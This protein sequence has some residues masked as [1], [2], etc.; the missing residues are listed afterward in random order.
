[1]TNARIHLQ[2]V[3]HREKEQRGLWPQL[4]LAILVTLVAQKV[5][6]QELKTEILKTHEFQNSKGG[7]VFVTIQRVENVMGVPYQ[8][9]IRGSCGEAKYSERK[10][11]PVLHVQNFCDIKLSSPELKENDQLSFMVREVDAERFNRMT[12]KLD[13]EKV[14][15]LKPTCLEEPKQV[16][17][18]IKNFCN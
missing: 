16:S 15:K 4:I 6:A 1:M 9:E 3:K 8:L 17:W 5:S 14:L 18:S 2:Q 11:A 10:K 7:D 12:R 13:P